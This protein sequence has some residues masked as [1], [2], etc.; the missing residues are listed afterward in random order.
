M[1]LSSLIQYFPLVLS[2][3]ITA[4]DKNTPVQD[5]PHN[6]N[7]TWN[8]TIRIA[9]ESLKLASVAWNIPEKQL[10]VDG[11]QIFGEW[12]LYPE[13]RAIASTITPGR[14]KR[15]RYQLNDIVKAGTVLVELESRDWM[16][17]Q[18]RYFEAVTKGNFLIQEYDRLNLLKDQDAIS[19]KAWQQIVAEKAAWQAAVATLEADIRL[20]G[21]EPAALNPAQPRSVYTLTA[22]ISGRITH[23]YISPGQW[24]ESGTTACNIA[25]LSQARVT[26]NVNQRQR[27]Q[28][29]QGD[30]LWLSTEG[31]SE[32]I[33]ARIQHIDQIMAQGSQTITIH[34][35][36][37]IRTNLPPVGS[38]VS[39]YRTTQLK[40][41]Q[42][43][44]PEAALRM[45]NGRDFILIY[46]PDACTDEEAVFLKKMVHII[47]RT[48]GNIVV[49]RPQD[50][51]DS[52]LI[53]T[54]GAYYIHAQSKT[55][56][57]EHDH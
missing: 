16:D 57:Q 25:D 37:L 20:H 18:G 8:D 46:L 32:K 4:C 40:A 33:P 29:Q 39:A 12:M 34:A 55:S 27:A 13:H 14:V 47:Q 30:T 17:L 10:S 5:D 41:Q 54:E 3:M 1:K 22:P 56:D 45:E 48:E 52:T 7:A 19:L 42:I 2:V 36:P 35:L 50:L 15:I 49:T 51:T 53:V 38:Y 9:H 28:F 44:L 11:E 6:D 43:A 23:S 24:M 26:L 31:I 21:V